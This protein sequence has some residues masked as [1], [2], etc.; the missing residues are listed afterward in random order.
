[1]PKVT[2]TH[3]LLGLNV[4]IFGLMLAAGMHPITPEVDSLVYWGANYGPKTT[5]GEWWRLGTAMFLHIGLLHLLC[6]MLALWNVGGF[7]E[8]VLGTAGFVVL[9]LLS[10][11]FGSITSVAWNPFVVSA[12]AS[13]AIFGLFGGLL[14]FLLR[15]RHA[16]APTFLAALRA[17]AL[18]FLGYNLL[19][20]LFQEGIDM[21]AHL[22]GLAG[23]FVG[24][25]VL[26]EPV[27]LV[28]QTRQRARSVLV[29]LIG[30]VV[31]GWLTTLLPRVEDVEAALQR[32]ASLD[33]AILTTFNRAI[34]QFQ[35]DQR[36]EAVLVR[37][38]AQ[39][40]LPPW[41][42]QREALR[43]LHDIPQLS[44]RQKRLIAAIVAYMT[45]RQEG[46]ELLQEALQRNDG[47]LI[48]QAQDKQ[49]QADQMRAQ[50]STR[51]KRQ[52]AGERGDEGVKERYIMRGSSMSRTRSPMRLMANT[53]SRMASP[54]KVESHQATLM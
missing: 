48:R 10:G 4:V 29:G 44:R 21:A 27:A 36:S 47:R 41:R 28:G 43:R 3:V 9:Y 20:G 39:D 15:Y 5:G 49:R 32:F 35:Q 6:N 40:V 37:T 19:F 26:A 13:G 23:G 25:L 45:T 14:A 34:S 1:M 31:L 42:A 30:A 12:G 51:G 16:L 17:N 54:G 8:R 46:W 24:G 53:V 2:A 11:L 22:G 18:V 33:V 7:M 38:L 52:G 50:F